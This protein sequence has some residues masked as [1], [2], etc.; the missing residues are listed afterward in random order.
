MSPRLRVQPRNAQDPV[1]SGLEIKLRHEGSAQPPLTSPNLQPRALSYHREIWP[2]REDER[3]GC[4]T[5]P[6]SFADFLTFSEI[7]RYIYG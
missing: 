6:G 3:I 1:N 5:T 7:Y 2:F 4:L